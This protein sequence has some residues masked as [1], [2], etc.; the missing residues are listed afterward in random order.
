MDIITI[1]S[2]QMYPDSPNKL[3]HAYR[4]AT[5]KPYGYIVLYLKANTPDHARLCAN[6]LDIIQPTMLVPHKAIHHAYHEDTHHLIAQHQ[7]ANN[8]ATNLIDNTI[9]TADELI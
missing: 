4:N 1:L 6:V 9:S 7:T 2:R 5:S 8:I 3:M